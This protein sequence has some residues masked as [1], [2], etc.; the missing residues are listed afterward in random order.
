M[1]LGYDKKLKCTFLTVQK[2]TLFARLKSGIFKRL[3]RCILNKDQG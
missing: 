2:I 1:T 3:V